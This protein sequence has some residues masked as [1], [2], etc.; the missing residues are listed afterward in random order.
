HLPRLPGPRG[1][2]L[3]QLRP[4]APRPG[5][6][7]SHRVGC[8]PRWPRV[9]GMA[10]GSEGHGPIPGV[11]REENCGFERGCLMTAKFPLG[12]LVATPGAL[13]CLR[14]SG[15]EPGFFLAKHVAGDWGSMSPDDR[16]AN[17][18]ALI[19]GSRI[20]SSYQTLTGQKL[21]IITEAVGDD[22]LRAATTVLLPDEY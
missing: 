9:Q 12:Q 16:Q 13:D 14:E 21:W 8:P 18:I 19:D 1:Q 11:Q 20:F 3:R 6:R 17:D 2:P 15:Q 22:G 10:P 4:R 5:P 7:R